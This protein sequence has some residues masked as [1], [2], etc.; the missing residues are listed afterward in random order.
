M[1]PAGQRVVADIDEPARQQQPGDQLSNRV[2]SRRID[3]AVDAVEDDEIEL[4]KIVTE[5]VVER[6][7]VQLNVVDA[8]PARVITAAL[9]VRLVEIACMER[10]P[11]NRPP[12]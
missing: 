9:D 1:R 12:R 6:P 7:G 2:A 11:R 10:C 3:P 8:Q 4:R 5:Q